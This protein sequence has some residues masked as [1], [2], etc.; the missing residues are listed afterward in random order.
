MSTLSSVRPSDAALN[1]ARKVERYWSLQESALSEADRLLVRPTGG[2][3]MTSVTLL[4]QVHPAAE[5]LSQADLEVGTAAVATGLGGL[6]VVL[7]DRHISYADLYEGLRGALL[8]WRADGMLPASVIGEPLTGPW[9]SSGAAARQPLPVDALL[10]ALSAAPA[11]RVP[12]TLSCAT[13]Q[14]PLTPVEQLV[15][16]AAIWRGIHADTPL[17]VVERMVTAPWPIPQG[18]RGGHRTNLSR[19]DWYTRLQFWTT[20]RARWR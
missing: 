13:G 8:A 5:I 14:D 19:W 20:K 15:A 4:E 6:E 10:D 3:W 2:S 1:P 12:Y 7:S 17:V 18:V 9:P 11:D 16:M